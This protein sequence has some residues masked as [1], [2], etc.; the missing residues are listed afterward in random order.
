MSDKFVKIKVDNVKS[1]IF[2]FLEEKVLQELYEKL[3]FKKK[4][5]EYSP[6]VIEGKWDGF[7]RLFNKY[8]KSFP[9]GLIS[10]TTSVLKKNGYKIEIEDQRIKPE[11][12]RQWNL[13]LPEKISS[14]YDF[15]QEAVYLAKKCTRGSFAIATGAGKTLTF[16]SIIA[17]IKTAPVIVYVPTLLLLYQTKEEIEKF[18]RD[19]SGK[20][21]EAGIVG[22]GQCDIKDITV[23]TIQTAITAF[24]MEYDKN[25]DRI[26]HLTPEQ[27]QKKNEKLLKN[28]KI[29]SEDP[30]ST[31]DLGFVVTRKEILQ[32]LIKNAKVIICD[33]CFQG[34]TKV[35]MPNGEY[36][37]INKLVNQGYQGEVMSWNLK[38]KKM[39]P[40][41]IIGYIK[42]DPSF[43]VVNIEIDNGII[44]CTS[45][46]LF[47]TSNGWKSANDL[48]INDLIINPE[49]RYSVVKSNP[50]ILEEFN[51]KVYC[52]EVEDNHNFITE[53]GVVHNCHR[54]SSSIYQEVLKN[55]P[56]A[57]YRFA[58]SGTLT[59]EDNTELLIQSI[60][61]KKLLH[62]SCSELIRRP[63]V[64][65]VRPYI[66]MVDV[67]NYNDKE[68]MTYAQI[69][70][71]CIAICKERNELIANIAG[72]MKKYGPTLLL[73]G[74]IDHGKALEKIIPN[75]VFIS[76]KMPKKKKQK[77]LDDLMS[78]ELEVLIASPI[79]DE[80]LNL[81]DLRVLIL[82]DGG[83]ALTKLYQRIGRVVR[84]SEGKNY[85]L[86]V[87]FKD[88]NEMLE[89][90]ANIRKKLYLAENEWI[91]TNV[92][93]N[94]FKS[95]QGE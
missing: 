56:L 86:V 72:Y 49:Y 51:E 25:K 17:E 74:I 3:A 79:I 1:K 5:I 47:L 9:T 81:P 93:A 18:L 14:L 62:V 37:Y 16:T 12:N 10:I 32:D 45:N 46:H 21:V 13:L 34:T 66:F 77:A 26:I 30:D 41:K 88:K 54:A 58:L 91:V 11:Q 87:D 24:D 36:E 64:K 68:Y 71:N 28:K 83:K 73:V 8:Y 67:P 35:L 44:T 60:F 38:S 40:K 59:R 15:Q 61:G 84:Q 65:I 43:P 42:K 27:I 20:P 7:T 75:S 53:Y 33:E 2:G 82:C 78:G 6:K 23:M 57:Y 19:K 94:K 95:I 52:L 85:G 22:N 70:K 63:D 76:G 31:E 92:S 48:K 89:E 55:S 39:E 90:H 69:R 4:N 50:V 80:G 29:N